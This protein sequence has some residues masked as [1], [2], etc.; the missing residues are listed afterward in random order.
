MSDAGETPAAGRWSALAVLT[1]ARTAMGFQFHSVGAVGPL[2]ADR[3][4]IASTE[5]G[6]LIGLFSL[7]GIVLAFPGGWLGA[8]FGDRRLVLT[9]LTLMTLGSLT[10][11]VATSMFLAIVGRSLSA[12]GA[13]LLNVLLTK[14][15]ADRF[16]GREIIWAMTILVNSWP[17]GITVASFT[18]PAIAHAWGPA[19][20]FD[21]AAAAAAVVAVAVA[22]VERRSGARD[23]SEMASPRGAL[24]HREI[25]LVTAAAMPWMLYNVGFAIMLGFVPAFL[26]HEGLSMDRAGILVGLCTLLFMM[27]AQAGGAIAQW[28]ARPEA[29]VSL[30]LVAF[31]GA[32]VAMPHASPLPALA[33]AGLFGGLPAG[34]LVAAPTGVLRPAS[35]GA[36]MGLFYTW[37]YAGMSCLPPLAGWM[38]DIVGGNAALHVAATAVGATL[39]S[40]WLFRL[41]MTREPRAPQRNRAITSLP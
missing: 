26:V 17:V 16:A 25:G 12:V 13:V 24:S 31:G 3:L 5:L 33:V 23:R 40:Y 37:F 41:M 22:V 10:L 14:M 7:P 32:L 30:G 34:A 36:G 35:R 6:L 27:S 9:G 11:G 2:L 39:P 19:V 4:E 20:A 29:L 28:L 21:V 1:F 18:L 38:Q 8:R 15:V